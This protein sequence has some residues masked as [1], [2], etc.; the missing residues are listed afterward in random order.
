MKPITIICIL[1]FLIIF[2]TSFINAGDTEMITICSG[3]E[4]MVVLCG[5]GDEQLG[6]FN[7]FVEEQRPG[8]AVSPKE[9]KLFQDID[10]RD[11]LILL[12]CIFFGILILC[13][14][15]I[16]IKRRRKEKNKKY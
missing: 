14:I 1:L 16:I 12:I 13:L 7:N 4:Q 5:G 10:F 3:D 6:Y 8:G 15:I 11:P 9:E 2:S